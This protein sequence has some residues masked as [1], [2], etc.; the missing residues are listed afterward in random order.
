MPD[1]KL[2]AALQ[3]PIRLAEELTG[4]I[5]GLTD[6]TAV[7]GQGL[8]MA[9]LPPPNSINAFEGVFSG[10][11][12]SFK[13]LWKGM[14]GGEGMS[15]LFKN[16][17]KQLTDSL[18]NM[19]LSAAM[20]F[21]M[22][23]LQK[24]GSKLFKTEGKATNK[25]RDKW[26]RDNFGSQ[27]QFEKLAAAAGVTADQIHRF[28]TVGDRETFNRMA[29]GIQAVI[30]KFQDA[31]QA[32]ADATAEL[33]K[34]RADWLKSVGGSEESFRRLAKQAGITDAEIDK[35]FNTD[36]IEDFDEAT[37]AAQEKLDRFAREQ[38][39][40]AERLEKAIEKYGFA[41][42]ELGKNIQQKKLDEQ[43]KDLIED[44]RVLIEAG[45]DLGKVNAKMSDHI[46]EYLKLAK[47]TGAEVPAAMR[48]MLQK[49]IE[50]GVLTDANG[51]K[52]EHLEDLGVTFAQTMTQGFDR[53]VEKL[54]ELIR[55]IGGVGDALDDIPDVTEKVI[56]VRTEHVGDDGD[57]TH[58][59]GTDP[60]SG[61]D[62]AAPYSRARPSSFLAPLNFQRGTGG[63]FLDFGEGTPA[64]LHGHE[65]V[66]TGA[67]ARGENADV[68]A[69]VTA[70][71]GLQT[72]LLRAVRENALQVRDQA[73]LARA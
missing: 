19:G 16:I 30:D 31:E 25:E 46:E 36:K 28:E 43:A 29:Q 50:S 55:K 73:L 56:R 72:V 42:D 70:V 48:P 51:K 69:M 21:G 59:G 24:L 5:V 52:I 9:M 71:Q 20:S 39:E 54:E 15:G 22:Q 14:S 37:Q 18:T 26:M 57:T 67:E 66:V 53:I 23:G 12:S 7:F 1:L 34:S 64:M 65:R 27:D 13:D 10:I 49:M 17:G 4:K 33:A 44:W 32:A 40:D 63:R 68:A 47:Q 45:V 62:E 58:G 38:E 2:G 8:K 41:W 11:K 6:A 35:I 61:D 60:D 3:P